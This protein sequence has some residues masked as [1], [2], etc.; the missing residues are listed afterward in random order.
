MIIIPARLKSTRLP[1]KL[2]L[3]L[4]DEP[5]IIK[6]AKIAKSI[7]RS[8]VA[9]DSSEIME[10]CE[11]YGIE[12]M[13]TKASHTSGTD[14]CAEVAEKLDIPQN[15]VVINLQGDEPFIESSVILGLKKAMQHELD[16]NPNAFMASCFKRINDLEANEHN[17][18]KVV[19]SL[20][21]HALYFSRSKI[22]Y[23]REVESSL[24]SSYYGHLGIYAFS[25]KSLLEFCKLPKS[26]LEEIEKLEQLRALWHNKQIY[27]LGVE[28][29]SI[30]IDSMEDYNLALS[31]I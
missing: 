27:M 20:S 24:D 28:S 5:I 22:P 9:T 26:P 7:D 2:L 18:V 4:G 3:P 25:K 6:V 23:H 21:N 16:S 14:R 8:I 10:V 11:K 15:E 13:M 31:R 12:C 17:L 30:G 1:N 19:L 29:N